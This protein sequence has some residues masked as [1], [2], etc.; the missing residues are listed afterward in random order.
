M[1]LMRIFDGSFGGSTLYQNPHFE[2]P[3]TKRKLVKME[4]EMTYKARVAAMEH[5][6]E[7]KIMNTLPH[8]PLEDVFE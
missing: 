3:N 6:K 2:S 5:Y 8:D 1:S 7:K 4:K